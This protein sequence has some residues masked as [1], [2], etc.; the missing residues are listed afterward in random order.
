MPAGQGSTRAQEQ[1]TQVLGVLGMDVVHPQVSVAQVW[2]K[3]GESGRLT[4]EATGA[5]IGALLESVFAALSGTWITCIQWRP[6]AIA[7]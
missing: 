7:G 3:F 1:L 2:D 6:P 4:H 5:E